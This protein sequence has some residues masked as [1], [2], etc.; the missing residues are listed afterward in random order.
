MN[1][2]IAAPRGV[3]ARVSILVLT[4]ASLSVHLTARAADENSQASETSGLQ[5]IVVTARK[6]E[7]S[8][9]KT[10]VLVDVVTQQ[11]IEDYRIATLY[12]LS[13]TIAPDV[14]VSSGFGPVGTL[15]Y[16]RGIGSGDTAS[17]VDQSVGLNID[18]VGMSAGVFY[19]SGTFDLARIDVL[20]GPQNLFFGKST[21]AGIIALHTADPTP[22]WESEVRVGDEFVANE[23][24]VNVYLSGPITDK[25]GI[26]VAGYY[27]Y[28][29]GWMYNPNPAANP[30]RLGGEEF[31]GRL[32]LKWDDPGTGFRAK[33]KFGAYNQYLTFNTGAWAQG[34]G[35]PTGTRQTLLV[36]PFDNCRL[37]KYNQGFGDSQPYNPNVNW[38]DTLGNPVPFE[39]GTQNPLMEDGRPYGRTQTVNSVL[40]LEYDITHA[41]TLS[42]VTGYSWVDT[43]DTAHGGFGVNTA[44]DVMGAFAES[45]VSEELRLTSSWKDSWINFMLGANY[46]ALYNS[47]TEFANIPDATVWGTEYLIQKGDQWAGYGQLLLTP[48]PQLEIA[49]GV[50]Y[51]HVYKYFDNLQVFNNF[52]IPGNNGVNQAPLLPASTKSIAQDNTSPEI[53]L[54]Y[55]L[56]DNVTVYGSFKE[57]YKG[58][59][60]N[61]QT[62]LLASWNP[63]IVPTGA[64]NPFGGERAQG[65]EAGVKAVLLDRHLNVAVTPYYY[66]FLGLQVS[67]LNYVTHAI[68]VT[69]GADAK[70]YGI[71]LSANYRPQ[72]AERL[73]ING[74]LAY[75][76]SNFTSFPLSPCWGGQTAAEGCVPSS[77]SQDLT[78]RTPY[79]APRWAGNLGV[80]YD[81]PIT[82][83]ATPY[84]ISYSANGTFSSGYYTVADLLPSSWQV[85]WATVDAAVRF[86][87][88]DGA[89]Q[90]SLIGRNLTNR[91]YVVGASD[92]GTITPGVMSDA[93]GY[94]NRVRQCYLELTVRPH[95]LFSW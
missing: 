69:N 21:T 41:L 17:Y 35:C 25:L 30:H 46:V 42:S 75:N 58:P 93:F 43:R 53:T 60:F 38:Y 12:D 13:Q 29:S 84:V 5:E 76:Q 95:K 22:D 48:I 11:Q 80:T 74:N 50:R 23:H 72:A 86:G 71:E 47:N 67:N 87:R 44:Y 32:T 94:I 68:E 6:R 19:K 3:F 31:G 20:K 66:K 40:Q 34:F 64:M 70:T 16:L 36:A 10:P 61:A 78:N 7:E 91:L 77:N 92:A 1:N 56:N 26:R 37:D 55:H 54:T 2:G 18:D 73:Q 57:G 82:R 59:G 33:L 62:F 90:V 8:V 14:H 81:Q 39:T 9:M 88:A 85:G 89:W 4:C 65:A 51:T 27:D 79:Q 52:P 63:A 83:Y 15:I 45:D 28:D 49:P 24:E